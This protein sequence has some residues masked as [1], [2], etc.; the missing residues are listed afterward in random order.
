MIPTLLWRDISLGRDFYAALVSLGGSLA[1]GRVAAHRHDFAELLWVVSGLGLHLVNGASQAL[2]EG[3]LTFV[4]PDD[5]HAVQ[6]APGETLRF[7]NVAFPL[8][9]WTAFVQAAGLDREAQGWAQAELPTQ[10]L[11]SP[12]HHENV[13]EA[14][15]CALRA[16]HEQPS[17]LELCRF[18]LA[19]L[20]PLLNTRAEGSKEAG[21]PPWLTR[22]CLAMQGAEHL[23]AGFPRLLA[24]SRVSAAHLAR[25]IRAW[26]GQTPTEF[27]LCL[28]LRRAATLLATTSLGILEIAGECGFE[29]AAYFYR[30]FR[31]GYGCAPRAFRLRTQQSVAP[32]QP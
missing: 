11:V 21:E 32:E 1:T 9:S 31:R 18:W 4:R 10:I 23:Q 5:C 25:T 26:R 19:T 17:R 2:T 20:S 6:A 30:R 16:F 7:I 29:N 15:A 13:R 8:D 24:L 14:F 27:I 28:R 22:A 12:A 3:S